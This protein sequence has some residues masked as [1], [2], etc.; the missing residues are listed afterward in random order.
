MEEPVAPEQTHGNRGGRGHPLSRDRA[1]GRHQAGSA[2]PWEGEMRASP[3]FIH[4]NKCGR[5]HFK[6][7][8]AK[9]CIK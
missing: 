6:V 5:I 9:S 1:G 2:A 8:T 4:R 3:P 7:Q